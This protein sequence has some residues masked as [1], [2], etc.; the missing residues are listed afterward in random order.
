MGPCDVKTRPPTESAPGSFIRRMQQPHPAGCAADSR[1][2]F[3][4]IGAVVPPE[5]PAENL[6]PMAVA[7]EIVRGAGYPQPGQGCG[8]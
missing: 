6:P 1:R 8:S 4:S 5:M 7:P 2:A 3:A